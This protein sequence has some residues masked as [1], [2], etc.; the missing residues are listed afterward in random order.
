FVLA[1]LEQRKLRP[2][3][4]ADRST[5]ARRLSLDLTGLPPAPAAVEAFVNDASPVAYEKLVER[6]MASPQWGEHRGRYW[7]DAARYADTHGIHFDNYR[8]SWVYRDWVIGAFNRNLPFDQF[9]IEQ[10]AGDLL[11]QRSLDQQIASGFNRCNITTNEGGIIDEEYLVLYT[12][13]RTETTSQVWMG[14]T[15]GC[16]VCH[17]HK[18][19]PI[20]QREF[21][22]LAAFFNNTT[23]SPM[24]GNI[25][26]TPPILVVP[27]T[28]DRPRWDALSTELAAAKARVDARKQ[29][30]RTEFTEWLTSATPQSVQALAPS[31]GL[32][33]HAPLDEGKGGK[34]K[35][36]VNDEPR[37][38]ALAKPATWQPGQVADKALRVGP[39]E[40]VAVAD[41][42]DFER[43]QGFSCGAW[44]KLGRNNITG[45]A[46]AR[47][48]DA[49][50]YRGWDLWFEAGKPGMHIVHHWDDD[51]LKVVAGAALKANQWHYVAATYDGSG[52]AAGV[53]L[54]VDGVVQPTTVAKNQLKG[55]IRTNVPLKIG[56]RHTQSRLEPL[57]IQDLKLYGR[58]LSPLEVQQA[59]K[60]SRAAYLAARPADKRSDA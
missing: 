37:E 2:A 50:G 40:T 18:F 8:E 39:D 13:D 41:A 53:K 48:D 33:F 30:A 14:L 7:L 51:A 46:V 49:N 32:V 21:Y 20:S 24:D 23:Q 6:L 35:V 38:I 52:K 22:A 26:D 1:R 10:L 55:T 43:D 9:T 19:D 4:E 27:S 56:Q 12:R 31:E 36:L 5:L 16:A 15:T 42:G 29:A 11:P 3:P 54:Y 25:K 45:A 59:S 58:T 34:L 44:I 60:V 47:M 57:T 17:D 28:E